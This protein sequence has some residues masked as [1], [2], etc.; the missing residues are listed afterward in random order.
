MLISL[1]SGDVSATP[2]SNNDFSGAVALSNNVPAVGSLSQ[3]DDLSDFYRVYVSYGDVLEVSLSMQPG[4]DF[5]L[6]LYDPSLNLVTSSELDNVVSGVY[7]ENMAITLYTPGF[8]FIEVGCFSGSGTFTVKASTTAEWTVMVYLDGDNNLEDAGII[9]FLEMSGVGST[10]EVNLL[11]Q[12]DRISGE[13]S[14]YGDWTGA[15]RYLVTSG[16][17]PTAA[18]AVSSLGEVN[19]GDP[20]TLTNFINWGLDNYPAN[21]YM[22]V[23][24]DHGGNWHGVCSDDT[25][26]DFLTVLEMRIA[27]DMVRANHS[28]FS[29]D[30]IGFDAC[31]MS[32]LEVLYEI[33][34][35]TDQIVASQANEP[36]PGWN[37]QTMCSAL[38]S[39]PLQGALEIS[40]QIAQTYVD[41]YYL[42]YPGYYE[43]DVTMAVIDASSVP[44]IVTAL[45]QVTL[46]MMSGMNSQHNYYQTAWTSSAKTYDDYPDLVSLSYS[47]SVASP[48][49]LE[50]QHASTLRNATMSAIT[51]YG[52]YDV[53]GGE[54]TDSLRGM[55]IYFP[56]PGYFDNTYRTSGTLFSAL[57]WDE[58]MLNYYSSIVQANDPVG[59]SSKSPASNPT[60]AVGASQTF[61]VTLDDSDADLIQYFWSWGDEDIPVTSSAITILPDAGDIG[62]HTLS[63]MVWDGVSYAFASWT[64]TVLEQPDLYISDFSKWDSQGNMVSDITSG[65]TTYAVVYVTNQGSMS[66]VFNATCYLDSVP[67]CSWYEVGIGPGTSVSLGTLP[68]HLSDLGMHVIQFWIDPADDVDESNESNNAMGFAMNVVKADWTLLVY[69]DG[70]NNLEPNMVDNFLQM[71]SI[72]SDANVS[73]VVQ[74][75]RISDAQMASIGLTADN[76]DSRFGDWADCL[77]FYV[78]YGML[79]TV[80]NAMAD[81]GKVNMAD[82]STLESFLSWGTS[83]FQADRYIVV[84]KD[85]GGSWMGCCQDATSGGDMLDLKETSFALREM[86]NL[87]GAPLDV[88]VFDDCLMGSIEVA[89]EF[90]DLAL[91]AVVSETTGWSNNHDYS[92][93]LS[94]LEN[95]S[96]MTSRSAALGM[97][98]LMHLV[99]DASYVTQ[100]VATY[101]LSRTDALLSALDS[102][103]GDL[104]DC[105]LADSGNMEMARLYTGSFT[106]SYPYDTVDLHMFVYNTMLYCNDPALNVTG[107]A[108]LDMLDGTSVDPV[109]LTCRA[110]PIA[111]F[112]HGMSAY[113]PIDQNHYDPGYQDI[114][115]FS[116][117]SVWDNMVTT[118]L[119]YSA[120][121]SFVSLDGTLGAAGWYVSA[122][123]ASF[124][125]YD[126]SAQVL[127]YF[128][129]SFGGPWYG[130]SGNV[131]V[132][133][134]GYTTLYHYATGSNGVEEVVRNV[135][136]RIDTV[137][138]N[139][140]AE[141]DGMTLT[142]L[143]SD[144][145]SGVGTVR[146][147]IDGGS[148]Q[149]YAGTFTVGTN[150]YM[151]AVEYYAVDV[152]GNA[153]VIGDVAVGDSDGIDP[154][155]SADIS[156]TEGNNG[157]YVSNVI[158][159]LNA[160]DDG[161]S[162]LQGITY[163]LD[164]GAWTAYSSPVTC[165]TEGEHTLNYR[166]KDN[167]GNEETVRTLTFKIDLSAP[168]TG[169]TINQTA[170][171]G[172]YSSPVSVALNATDPASGVS[173]VSYRL[174]GGAW[175]TY[176]NGIAISSDGAWFIEWKATDNAGNTGTIGN[177]TVRIDTTDPTVTFELTGFNEEGWGLNTSTVEWFANDTGS[178][179]DRIYYRVQHGEWTLYTG[180]LSFNVTGGYRVDCYAV[181]AANNSGPVSN[182]TIWID[183]SAP[184]TTLSLT[185][186]VYEGQYLNAATIGYEIID[187]GIG[188]T[189]LWYRV[190]DGNWTAFE[191]TFS[192]GAGTF[193]LW[194]YSADALDNREEARYVNFTVIDASVPAKVMGL[195]T[196][197][198]DGGVRLSWAAPDDGVL[199]ITSFL[200]YR[201]NGSGYELL[202]TVTM[203]TNYLDGDVDGG[204]TYSYQVVAVNLLGEG[205]VSDAVD[206]EVPEESSS[207]MMFVIIAIVAVVAVAVVATMIIIRRK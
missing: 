162:G 40:V 196:N 132:S 35:Y 110:T 163:S 63:L 167:F 47:L 50:R 189:V 54:D 140:T 85:H 13:D 154:V 43:A 25:S 3:S 169:S 49:A 144:G 88:L 180:S 182:V 71:A 124:T 199:P 92:A 12:M 99:D 78:E 36:G 186:T 206:A 29:F 123:E 16:M 149:T 28:S 82:R 19:M 117:I 96:G 83:T 116:E 203:A 195:S 70:D 61:S 11:V 73:V 121:L 112:C 80:E 102:Y 120:P 187:Q 59:I 157:W 129:Y 135:T 42:P 178:G 126:P 194:Y 156:G 15:N 142:L 109:V 138:P 27:F 41:S 14:T 183:V 136:F 107:Q 18:N 56:R 94:F 177:V 184:V 87:T 2:D 114:G 86:T 179:V 55:S 72:G 176:S 158:V 7:T 205:I 38:A 30:V 125:V 77:R 130:Y 197:I 8:Y 37:Y 119:T 1:A 190:G 9:D 17:T 39:N 76:Y 74:F 34:G 113:F 173:V 198:E 181:D 155:S 23:L 160:T 101:D 134:Q 4:T 46:D 137:A 165:A 103:L 48:T 111:S 26:G 204:V 152:A 150:G 133:D 58:M 145:T 31:V 66:C 69:M 171:N 143:A 148:W 193:V 32:G 172:W 147:R 115:A 175:A 68:M 5:D 105:W 64:V 10:N 89:T 20:W 79:P 95:D 202:A 98:D 128:N 24:W 153:G 141:V 118:Y 45:N 122:V 51:F 81:L 52:H 21:N 146:Y 188:G 170:Y 33:S 131:M 57:S 90:R 139:V 62:V 44:G 6:Y 100:C 53:F 108:V 60:V 200:I 22:L 164:G 192:F 166:A 207:M 127:S 159:T 84:L 168:L 75:D 161:G 174:N 91:F 106:V 93:I 65:R 97:T 201:S 191:E 67:F 104:G 151:Y 185:G